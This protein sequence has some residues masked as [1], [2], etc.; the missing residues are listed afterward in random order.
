MTPKLV[1]TYFG[2]EGSF[3]WDPGGEFA[4]VQGFGWLPKKRNISSKTGLAYLALLNSP[5]FAVLLS[6]ASN[7]VAGGQWD[8]SPRFVRRI[9]LPD[10]AGGGL[11]LSLFGEIA[12]L[13][14]EVVAGNLTA[15]RSEL[16]GLSRQA[17]GVSIK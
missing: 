7:S 6:A 14:A 3:G 4:V 10:F 8:L 13:G 2:D 16:D 9:P 1:S 11:D 17:Y 15:C 5:V 12:Q